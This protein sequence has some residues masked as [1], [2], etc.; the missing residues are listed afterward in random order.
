MFPMGVLL[1]I[2]V[3]PEIDMLAVFVRAEEMTV[4]LTIFEEMAKRE[5]SESDTMA[6]LE[7]RV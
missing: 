4:A 6:T 3:N 5:K 2:V 7:L 1:L